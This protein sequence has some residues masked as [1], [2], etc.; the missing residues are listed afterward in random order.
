[1]STSWFRLTPHTRRPALVTTLLA[2][3]FAGRTTAWITYRDPINCSPAERIRG[4]AVHCC[5]GACLDGTSVSWFSDNNNGICRHWANPCLDAVSSL[6]CPSHQVLTSIT[7]ESV[8]AGIGFCHIPI[9]GCRWAYAEYY[10]TCCDCPDGFIPA[11][12][13]VSTCENWHRR[14]QLPLCI[15]CSEPY[16]QIYFNEFTGQYDCKIVLSPLCKAARAASTA[17]S[18]LGLLNTWASSLCAITNLRSLTISLLQSIDAVAAAIVDPSSGA[19]GT[20]YNAASTVISTI[21]AL[22][23]GAAIIAAAP[24]E[25][26]LAVALPLAYVTACNIVTGLGAGLLLTDTIADAIAEHNCPYVPQKRAISTEPA[27]PDM[28]ATV[29][30]LA[31]RDGPS[32]PC[33]EFVRILPYEAGAADATRNACDEMAS[34]DV[35]ALQAEDERVASAVSTLQ[36]VCA[37]MRDSNQLSFMS[38][39][40]NLVNAVRRLIPYCNIGGGEYPEEYLREEEEEEET[41]TLSSTAPSSLKTSPPEETAT[42]TSTAASSSTTPG[43][44]SLGNI[45]GP[46]HVATSFLVHH[47][48]ITINNNSWLCL[49]D[50]IHISSEYYLARGQV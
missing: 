21:H 1:M 6:D 34:F 14:W 36:Q 8:D 40:A 17:A 27:E 11:S 12:F 18:A 13:E 43:D 2:C 9:S 3:L 44:P 48:Y 10:A 38:D 49:S 29:R 22:A 37:S 20:K 45:S 47:C 35:A 4:Q 19:L 23:L 25:V 16:E 41:Y 30:A 15:G 24:A 39:L 50:I 42:V 7:G 28:T 46:Q 32:N 5:T 33:S 31:R 26:P